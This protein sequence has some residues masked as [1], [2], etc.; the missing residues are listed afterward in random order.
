M[1]DLS[2][3]GL[4]RQLQTTLINT[5]ESIGEAAYA[6]Y[7]DEIKLMIADGADVNY[8]NSSLANSLHIFRE[9]KEEIISRLDEL[10]E[11]LKEAGAEE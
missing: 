6:S 11:L 8:I 10:E 7:L 3:L 5:L 9:H 4:S 2:P 1:N